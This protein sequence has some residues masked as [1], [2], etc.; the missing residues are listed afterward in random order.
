MRAC[1]LAGAAS[2]TPALQRQQG[3]GSSDAALPPRVGRGVPGEGCAF[4]LN[5]GKRH[6]YLEVY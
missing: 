1:L 5:S 6:S 4:T 2:V 3:P